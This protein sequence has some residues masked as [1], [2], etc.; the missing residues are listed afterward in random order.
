MGP[1]A[2]TLTEA[3]VADSPAV[4][5]VYLLYRGNELTYIGVA[6]QGDGIRASLKNH[7]SGACAGCPRQATSFAY[8]LTHHPRRRHRQHLSAHRERHGGRVP[9][10]NECHP[11]GA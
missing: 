6:E 2:I 5:G 3:G 1:A 10:C 4:P 9:P 11:C 7:H 8:E